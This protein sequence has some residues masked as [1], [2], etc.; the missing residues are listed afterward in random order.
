MTISLN[1]CIFKLSGPDATRYLNGQVTNDVALANLQTSI[2]SFVTNAKGKVESDIW[3]HCLSND[4]PT[5]LIDGPM[6]LREE[7]L[8]RLDKYLIADDAA[9][10]DVTDQYA[11]W[12]LLEQQSDTPS[13]VILRKSER[14]GQPGFD[15]IS[16]PKLLPADEGTTA[17]EAEALRI[18][19]KIPSWN[20]ELIH[21]LLPLDTG[22]E[23]QSINYHK[24]CYIG[25]EVISRMKRAKKTNQ[26]I[27]RL[28][29]SAELPEGSKL[30]IGEKEVGT[31]TSI[32]KDNQANQYIGLAII[33]KNAGDSTTFEVGSETASIY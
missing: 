32:A 8:F 5:Y 6:E 13:N 25:Q 18:S 27:E 28:K 31:I 9:F 33:K 26:R 17:E 11:L 20:E 22:L 24:G 2:F 7:L 4:E 16:S 30:L 3:I 1:R 14:F 10:E 15:W 21:G 29:L 19:N 12:H 23:N